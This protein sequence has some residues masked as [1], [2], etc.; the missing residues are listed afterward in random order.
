MMAPAAAPPSPPTAVP[1][2]ALGPWAHDMAANEIMAVEIASILVVL[3]ITVV[4]SHILSLF[5]MLSIGEMHIFAAWCNSF[6]QSRATIDPQKNDRRAH[7]RSPAKL[8][9]LAIQESG[10]FCS[11]LHENGNDC[12]GLPMFDRNVTI[13]FK[14]CFLF[15]V[16]G[17]RPDP[18]MIPCA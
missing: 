18:A 13:L 14:K 12:C 17:K 15:L 8:P 1:C 5:R 6:S 9:D 3:F 2:W 4:A 10:N 11:P 7:P 16:L